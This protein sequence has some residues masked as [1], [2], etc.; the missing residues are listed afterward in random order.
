MIAVQLKTLKTMLEKIIELVKSKAGEIISNEAGIPAEKKDAAVQAT[1]ASLVDGLKQA[2]SSDNMSAFTS[3]VGSD[4]YGNS[5]DGASGMLQGIQDRVVKALTS[6]VGL[7]ASTA[8]KISSA[9]I[10][11]VMSLFSEKVNDESEPGFNLDSLTEGL[12]GKSGLMDMVG[13]LF[14]K[15]QS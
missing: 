12:T 6:K 4:R 8:E 15:K 1:T 2:V 7:N 3:L 14:G 13:G 5:D 10:P 9:V 11:A